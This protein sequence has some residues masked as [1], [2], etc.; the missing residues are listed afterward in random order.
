LQYLPGKPRREGGAT[1]GKRRDDE[2]KTKRIRELSKKAWGFHEKISDS[3]FKHQC[4]HQKFWEKILP[5]NFIVSEGTKHAYC[6]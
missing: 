6:T 5:P 4:Q 2:C 1:Q 3:G